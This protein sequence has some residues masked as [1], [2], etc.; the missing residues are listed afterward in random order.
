MKISNN[1]QKGMNDWLPEEFAVRKYIFDTWRKV[2]T[3]FGYLEYL[4]PV[5]ESADIYRAK[6]G[7]DVGGKELMVTVDRAG[8]ELALRPEMTPSITRV[9]SKIYES[10]AKPLRLFSIANF[11]RNEKPQRGRNR[12]FWQLNFDVFGS[13]STDA[14]IEVLQLSLEIML[15]FGATQNQFKLKI[16]DRRILQDIITEFLGIPQENQIQAVRTLDKYSKM[17]LDEFVKS[18][19]EL[20]AKDFDVEVLK[21]IFNSEKE[22]IESVKSIVDEQ[23]LAEL[24]NIINTLESLGYSE[25]VEWS[26]SLAR[27]F[28]YYDGMVF[29]V[30][31]NNAEN[32]RALFGGGRYNGLASIFGSQSFP[33]VGCAPGDETTKLFLEAWNLIPQNLKPR[34]TYI[35]ILSEVLKKDALQLAQRLRNKGENIE[36]SLTTQKLGKAL[37]YANKAGISKVVIL[38]EN[39]KVQGTYKLKDMNSGEEVIVP[40]RE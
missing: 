1:P 40:N 13:E 2:C 27:G 7:E 19:K 36:V 11:V 25:S 37:E 23:V 8:R 24:F 20:G 22:G 5:L 33:A 17:E 29:E 14:D 30:F 28:D 16:N 10:S 34:R 35:P 31:D 6:S 38:G 12:E 18:L 32:K 39:E 15:A 21:S 9:V 4:T 3:Q 26:P